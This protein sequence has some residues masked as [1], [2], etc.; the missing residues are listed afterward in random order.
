M[1]ASRPLHL[2]CVAKVSS[3]PAHHVPGTSLE[4][5]LKDLMS[6]T[7]WGPSGDS[8]RRNAE[9]D[10]L[11]KKLFFR[12]NIPCIIY[13]FLFSTGRTNIQEF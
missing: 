1:L 3:Q 10:N 12:R 13:L 11:M 2:S 4:G 8:Q 6:G 7:Y 5:L 9:A